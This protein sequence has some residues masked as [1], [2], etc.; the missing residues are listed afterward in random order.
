VLTLVGF[1]LHVEINKRDNY[2]PMAPLPRQALYSSL[3]K[4]LKHR[5]LGLSQTGVQIY[6]FVL[7]C[8]KKLHNS[9]RVIK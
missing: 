1:A 7:M 8:G 5:I 2:N 9:R 6:S 4:K 3:K